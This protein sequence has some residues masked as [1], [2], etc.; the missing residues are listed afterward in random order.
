[1]KGQLGETLNNSNMI[2]TGFSDMR[3]SIAVKKFRETTETLSSLGYS[4]EEVTQIL[5]DVLKKCS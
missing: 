4:K 1:M 2:Y 3:E 5:Q